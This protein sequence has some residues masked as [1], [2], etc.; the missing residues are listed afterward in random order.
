MSALQEMMNYTFVSKY[1]R[2][3]GEK[4]RRE[5]WKEAVNRVRNMMLEYYADKDIDTDIN[6]AYDMMLKK[7]ILGSQRAL[8]FGGKPM[9][10]KMDNAAI[11]SVG[12]MMAPKINA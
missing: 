6:W 1:A 12:A 3:D 2:W 9:L 4:K 7:K 5:T 8:Q 10:S 11:G